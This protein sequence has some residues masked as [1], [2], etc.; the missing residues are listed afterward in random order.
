MVSDR[1]GANMQGMCNLHLPLHWDDG[2]QWLARIKI[3][4]PSWAPGPLICLDE[5]V[6]SEFG[7][8]QIARRVL[9]QLVPRAWLPP[10]PIGE[11][12][13]AGKCV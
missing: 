5:E 4:W 7:M 1:D 11:C 2:E 12:K 13:Q 10:G 3:P 6:R 8:L 9:G